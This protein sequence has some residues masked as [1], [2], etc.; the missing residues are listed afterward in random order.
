[1]LK[2]SL[3]LIT[4]LSL[5]VLTG[6]VEQTIKPEQKRVQAM[7]EFDMPDFE[8]S[9]NNTLKKISNWIA[10]AELDNGDSITFKSSGQR[11]VEGEGL[12]SLR[13]RG[14]VLQVKF[15]V[16]IKLI[17]PEL[18]QV[19]MT[20]FEDLP[21]PAKGESDRAYVFHNQVKD[22]ALEMVDSLEEYLNSDTRES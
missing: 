19:T 16:E 6:C 10:V 17:K 8:H 22:Q 18:I 9:T 13:T 1:M 15:N 11:H 2:K 5:V 14:N 7:L 4:L 3:I 12:V 20:K 21:G